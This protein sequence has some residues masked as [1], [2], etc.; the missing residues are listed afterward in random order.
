[1]NQIVIRNGFLVTIA[2]L[3]AGCAGLHLP[4]LTDNQ[5]E[6][7]VI[8]L[9]NYAQRVA[10]MTAEQQRIEYSAGNQ[11]FARDKDAI[12]RVRL[13]LLLATPGASFSDAARAASLL[14]PMA[15]PSDAASPLHSLARLLYTQLNERA[16][17]QK[18]A[19]Q[20]REQ[21]EAR[22]EAARALREQLEALKEVERT[23]IERG[24][25]SQPR[26]R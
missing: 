17:E 7:Q 20:M 22:K 5:E 11:A 8:Q 15:T 4:N 12:S 18:R 25:E 14:E 9:I 10:S 1:M 6:R 13:A 3:L 2:L 24:Q 26:R 21:V 19:N 23:I 16:S